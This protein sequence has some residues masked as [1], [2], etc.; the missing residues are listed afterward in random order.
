MGGEGQLAHPSFHS[1][2]LSKTERLSK[3]SESL[4]IRE[5]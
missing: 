1:F 3:G 2:L 5:W 4:L